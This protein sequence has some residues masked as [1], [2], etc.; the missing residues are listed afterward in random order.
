MK[1]VVSIVLLATVLAAPALAGNIEMPV[2]PPPTTTSSS[3]VDLLLIALNL[4]F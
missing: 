4:F 2:T 1:K 3:T